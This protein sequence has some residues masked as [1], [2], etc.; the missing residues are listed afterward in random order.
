MLGCERYTTAIE[1]TEYRPADRRQV[2][3]PA[4]ERVRLD[5]AGAPDREFS[6]SG[7]IELFVVN[8]PDPA[9]RSDDELHH[10]PPGAWRMIRRRGRST[11]I[12]S[13]DACTRVS[14]PEMLWRS[15]WLSRSS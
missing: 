4:A 9:I 6:E 14:W 11:S 8:G 10:A 7:Q 12:E 2:G 3:T 1:R 15:A 13:S 5:V